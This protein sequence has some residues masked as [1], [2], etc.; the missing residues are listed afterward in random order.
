MKIFKPIN[1]KQQPDFR[2]TLGFSNPIPCYR[3]K[4][5]H[6]AHQRD[7]CIPTFTTALFTTKK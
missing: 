1:I 2:M 6:L 4:G 7:I 5:K 3:H